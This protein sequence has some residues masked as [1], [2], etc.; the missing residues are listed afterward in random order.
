MGEMFEKDK[1]GGDRSRQREGSDLHESL[2]SVKGVRKDELE[3]K[4]LTVAQL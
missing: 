1:G 4:S 3:R 2:T